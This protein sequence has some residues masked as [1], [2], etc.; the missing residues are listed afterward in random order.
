[1]SK[2]FSILIP[3]LLALPGS[4][5]AQEMVRADQGV[6]RA[7]GPSGRPAPTATQIH[8]R[9]HPFQALLSLTVAERQNGLEQLAEGQ[10]EDLAALGARQLIRDQATGEE[11]R[12]V[13]RISG[14]SERN[15]IILL[16]EL[17]SHIGQ[18]LEIPRQVLR[19]SLNRP[20]TVPAYDA[21]PSSAV[22][23][24]SILIARQPEQDDGRLIAQSLQ[25]NPDAR[26]P[27]LAARS[28]ALIG[29]EQR[30]LAVATWRNE[31]LP[32]VVRASAAVALSGSDSAAEL[33]VA[34]LIR[35]VLSSDSNQSAAVGVGT[36]V[37]VQQLA[38]V[39]LIEFLPPQS[40]TQLLAELLGESHGTLDPVIYALAL[41]ISPARVE[42][43]DIP[44]SVRAYVAQMRNGLFIGF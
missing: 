18:D 2:R 42:G 10:D 12:I 3:A 38:L 21:R 23:L 31:A 5:A 15:Q 13:S 41:R 14:W 1:M 44:E 4:A 11:G 22:D 27:W 20:T 6:A 37:T 28:L 33:F 7:E 40:A 16:E 30:A 17:R 32:I 36:R 39:G 19:D 29:P 34:S 25:V 24:A 8:E 43:K 9:F 35:A 26:G